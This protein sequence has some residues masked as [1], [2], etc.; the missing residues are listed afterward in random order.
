[1]A[2]QPSQ[3]CGGWGMA[4]PAGRGRARLPPPQSGSTLQE[5]PHPEEDAWE[6]FQH[7]ACT[8]SPLGVRACQDESSLCRAYEDFRI[9]IWDYQAVCTR[10]V[11][12]LGI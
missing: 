12:M 6:V 8:T 2:E 7:T 9:W 1:M 3:Q 11:G 10:T 5:P 4:L